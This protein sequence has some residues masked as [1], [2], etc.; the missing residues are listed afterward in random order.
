MAS[1]KPVPNPA[2]AAPPAAPAESPTA[3]LVRIL[4]WMLARLAPIAAADS[5]GRANLN[6]GTVPV[7]V[8]Q[9][10]AARLNGEGGTVLSFPGPSEL[11]AAAVAKGR[12]AA[13][14]VPT[15][16][17]RP[18]LV[19]A[20]PH[21][22]TGAMLPDAWTLSAVVPSSVRVPS[23]VE[24]VNMAHASGEVV[25]FGFGKGR[26]LTLPG[27]MTATKRGA[28]PAAVDALEQIE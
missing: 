8:H 18:S 27:R 16:Q 2:P 1:G 6:A 14:L 28:S 20:H 25:A 15:Y 9:S 26:R 7:S 21:P 11:Y 23:F 22:E 4:G 5:K 10:F 24:A 17:P 19:K 3:F 12:L 13:V